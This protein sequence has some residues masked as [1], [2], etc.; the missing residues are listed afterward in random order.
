MSQRREA[1]R[2]TESGHE[3]AAGETPEHSEDESKVS[4]DDLKDVLDEIEDVLNEIENPEEWVSGF[5]QKGGE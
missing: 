5:K 4:A 1:K 3:E 2:S